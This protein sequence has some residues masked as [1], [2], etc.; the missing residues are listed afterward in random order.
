MKRLFFIALLFPFLIACNDNHDND[1][2]NV[3]TDIAT[4][5]N[6]DQA[7]KFGLLL[8]DSTLLWVAGSEVPY[9]RPK[10]GQR[11]IVDYSLLSENRNGK[12]KHDVLINDVYEVL[13]KGIFNITAT[14]QDSIGNDNIS[15]KN[16]WIGGDFLNVEFVYPGYNATHYINLVAD[17]SKTYTD[18]KIHLEFRHNANNDYPEYNKWGIVSFNLKSLQANTTDSVQLVIHTKEFYYGDEKYDITYKFGPGS[19][20]IKGQ[21]ISL[22]Q[23]RAAIK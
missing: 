1:Y 2:Q 12:Y 17:A 14:T 5:E 15:I 18:G 4:V 3:L 20:Q 10:D 19:A 21:K 11:I 9:Y 16:M 23:E 13:T 7:T 22:K 8:D 6:P